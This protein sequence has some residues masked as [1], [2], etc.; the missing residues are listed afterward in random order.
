MTPERTARAAGLLGIVAVLTAYQVNVMTGLEA[1]FPPIE[2]C[3]SVSRAVRSGPGLWVFKGA[4]LPLAAGMAWTWWRLPDP[5]TSR[6][7]RVMGGLG[8][9]FLLIYAASLGT[10]GDLYRWMRRYGVVFY[11]GMTALAQLLV[12]SRLMKRREPAQGRPRTT[13]LLAIT[14]TWIIGVVSAFK[15]ELID[16]PALQDRVQNALEWNF[17]LAISLTFIALAGIIRRTA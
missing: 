13:Y 7:I 15:R 5:L 9:L 10:D 2:G 6:P 8:A 16:D 1:C 3:M 17:A 4:A 14:L 12:A 11:F